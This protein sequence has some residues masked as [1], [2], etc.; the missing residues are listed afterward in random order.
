MSLQIPN[1][2]WATLDQVEI[3]SE[4]NFS[5]RVPRS[6]RRWF[7]TQ[8]REL[9]RLNWCLRIY[10]PAKSVIYHP[11]SNEEAAPIGRPSDQVP[12]APPR[13]PTII[14]SRKRPPRECKAVETKPTATTWVQ[15]GP[16][17]FKTQSESETQIKTVCVEK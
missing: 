9:G 6:A 5:L 13:A 3:E 11:P 16:A 4:R 12:G 8:Y 2:I 15:I 10:E 1:M 7:V 17:A 14:P